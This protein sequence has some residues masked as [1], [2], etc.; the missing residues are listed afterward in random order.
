MKCSEKGLLSESQYFFFTQNSSYSKLF[1]Y[2]KVCGEFFAQE[3]YKIERG[4]GSSPLLFFILDGELS[5]IYN[6]KKHIAKKNQLVL[7]DCNKPHQYFV[8]QNNTCHFYFFHFDG[9]NAYEITNYLINQNKNIIFN[10]KDTVSAK[11]EL[12]SLI[13]K[14]SNNQKVL[15][16][17][18]STLV[19]TFLCYLQM[20]NQF[21]ENLQKNDVYQ[22]SRVIDFIRDNIYEEISLEQL[23]EVA[24]LSKFHFSRIFKHEMGITP[25]EYVTQTKINLAKTILTTTNRTIADIAQDLCFASESSFIN[26][27]KARTGVTPNKYRISKV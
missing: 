19:Y 17:E 6:H 14:L 1:Y 5:I 7:I 2:I 4:G 20:E 22:L 12:S 9:S 25:I 24:A 21:S 10:C 27:F 8:N 23:S 18:L 13:S 26:A 3:G 16:L 11:T 15:D